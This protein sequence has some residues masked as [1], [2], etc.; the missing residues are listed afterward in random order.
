MPRPVETLGDFLSRYDLATVRQHLWSLLEGAVNAGGQPKPAASLLRFWKDLEL[1]MEKIFR[2]DPEIFRLAVLRSGHAS[3]GHIIR[4]I[5]A[6]VRPEKIFVVENKPATGEKAGRFDLLIVIPDKEQRS[7]KAYETVIGLGCIGAADVSCSLHKADRLYP[8]L[9]SGHPF[10]SRVCTSENMVYDDGHT[11]LPAPDP[12]MKAALTAQMR[13]VFTC[14]LSRSAS[15]LDTAGFHRRKGET[16]MGA[17]MLHQAAE[18]VFR[19]T[20]L[21]LLDHQEPTHSLQQL[22]KYCRRCAPQLNT[23]FP[24]DTAAEQQLLQLLEKA[25]VQARY[26]DHYTV[27]PAELDLLFQRVILLQ[28]IAR[29][30]F[31]EKITAFSRS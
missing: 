8:L 29:E 10:Y 22:K 15:F 6:V 30:V 18:Q 20:T 16:A 1:F 11:G 9:R 24:E 27:S 21:A 26:T 13:E 25:Y 4:F 14:G 17:F 2:A 3:P 12:A 5:A 7:F 19:S 31:E 28:N 23:V